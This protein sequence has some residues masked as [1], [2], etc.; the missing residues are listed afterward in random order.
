MLKSWIDDSAVSAVSAWIDARFKEKWAGSFD[1][2]SD[3]GP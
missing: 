2:F 1:Q 3:D